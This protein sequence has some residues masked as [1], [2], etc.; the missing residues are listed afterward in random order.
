MDSETTPRHPDTWRNRDYP[1]LYAIAPKVD[2][3]GS[4]VD[5]EFPALGI[6]ESDVHPALR[7]LEEGG[8]IR[9]KWADDHGWVL[10]LTG[11]G[12]RAVGMWPSPESVTDE[13][14]ASLDE[15][16][17]SATD[18]EERTRWQKIRDAIG[19]A[20]RDLAVEVLGAAVSRGI[21]GA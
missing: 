20:T 1:V 13:I 12:R 19:G 7:A 15:R 3:S 18:P 11:D 21:M 8:Y 10:G 16:I 4:L 2:E 17:A 14:V 6:D 9:M 5:M